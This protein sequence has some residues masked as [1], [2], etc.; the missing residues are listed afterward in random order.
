VD[1]IHLAAD[2]NQWRALSN[3][4][5]NRKVRGICSLVELELTAEKV[6]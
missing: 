6:L 1:C 4:V 5:M 2:R 3:T